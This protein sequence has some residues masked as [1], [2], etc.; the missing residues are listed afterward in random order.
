[1]IYLKLLIALCCLCFQDW[2]SQVDSGSVVFPA[3]DTIV[4]TPIKIRPDQVVV[5]EGHP[6]A[7]VLY[8]GPSN[9]ALF[10]IVPHQGPSPWVGRLQ[11][12]NLEADACVTQST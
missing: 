1:M 3:G 4:T 6:K 9:T 5:I 8:R 11:I 2:Q 10:E 7:K 12:R